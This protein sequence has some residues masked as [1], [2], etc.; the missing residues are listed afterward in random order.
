MTGTAFQLF[1]ANK[2]ALSLAVVSACFFGVPAEA[3]DVTERVRGFFCDAKQDQVAFLTVQAEGENEEMA[4]DAVNKSIAKASC[5]YYL[6]ATA[7]PTGEHTVMDRG[8]VFKLESYVFLPEKVER[9]RGTVLG[10]L[11]VT[12]QKQDI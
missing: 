2:K 11:R 9:W 3:E 8:L 4:A 7:I 12:A 10:S 6:P 1:P 5:A